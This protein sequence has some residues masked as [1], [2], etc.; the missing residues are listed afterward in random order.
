MEENRSE[1]I[2][3]MDAWSVPRKNK[4]SWSAAFKKEAVMRLLR[5]EPVHGVSR[6]TSVPEYKLQRWRNCALV[7]ID[8]ALRER[9]PDSLQNCLEDAYRRIN[10][11]SLEVTRL[12]NRGRAKRHAALQDACVIR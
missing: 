12:R 5:G 6:E 11:L 4:R 1:G 10:E 7:G 8:V 9:E 3:V 2:V